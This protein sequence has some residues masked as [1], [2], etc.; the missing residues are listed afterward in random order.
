MHDSTFGRIVLFLFALGALRYMW[1][2]LRI[3]VPERLHAVG[4]LIFVLLLFLA[5]A[6]RIFQFGPGLAG[7]ITFAAGGVWIVLLSNWLVACL[8]MDFILTLL[9]IQK[10]FWGFS[11]RS[12]DVLGTLT[13]QRN[14]W[15]PLVFFMTVLATA[16]CWYYG[17]PRQVNY[18]IDYQKLELAR[19]IDRPVRIAVLSDIHFDPM[20]PLPKWERLL[21]DLGKL[22]PDMIVLLGDISDLSERDLDGL[23]LGDKLDSLYAPLGV[24]A[25]TGNH[26]GYMEGRHPELIGWYEL[27][28]IEFLQD[29][30]F[31]T[32]S[33]CLTGRDDLSYV[34][35][36]KRERATLTS[37]APDPA[38]LT[39]KAWIILD[40]QPKGLS[41]RDIP[42]LR[43][44]PDFGISGHTHAGQFF[45]W[46]V[47]IHW[48]WTLSSGRG[49]LGG[50]PWFTSSGFGQ[51]GPALRVGS[52]TEL[53]ILDV[54]GTKQ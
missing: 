25:V 53:V 6:Y 51:W 40:H 43:V 27:H 3:L 9:W 15:I 37:I 26:E 46:T 50:I 48:V 29:Q 24:F 54:S 44:R 16:G 34:E 18:I 49:E 38:L 39:K 12:R 14:A 30:S 32:T 52:K 22:K 45:P 28:G 42:G 20:F 5:F 19:P 7:E 41:A 23:G 8:G 13:R 35:R 11:T 33:V 4:G 31:C 2:R 47:V 36:Q 21:R 10:R 1:V 17:Y